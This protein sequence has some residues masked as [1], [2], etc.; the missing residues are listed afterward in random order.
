MKDNALNNDIDKSHIVM[1]IISF[2]VL[3]WSV[4]KPHTYTSWFLEAIPA[5]IMILV[6]VITYKRF[7]FSKF[8]YFVVLIHVIVLLIGSKYT[9]QRNP[10]FNTFMEKFDLNRNYYDRVGHFMQGVT[11]ALIAKEILWRKKYL[12]KSKMFYFIVICIVLAI[13]ASYEL[14]EF[15]ASRISGVP[16]SEVLSYQGDEWD[17][18]WDMIMALMGGF[19]S[20]FVFGPIH[21]NSIEKME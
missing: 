14:V 6:L 4:I 9:Y 7:K 16:G 8:V 1:L 15:A 12:K 3:I 17:T 20:L 11:P 5:I 18:Q 10:L 21:D 13:S 2:I 19:T